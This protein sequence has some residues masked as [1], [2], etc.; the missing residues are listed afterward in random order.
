MKPLEVLSWSLR[1]VI[2]AS[3]GKEIIGADFSAIEA[4]VLAWLAGQDDVLAVLADP[5][6]DLYVEDAR[7]I[8]SDSRQLGKVCRLALGYSMGPIKFRDTAKTYGIDLAL[9]EARRITLLWRKNNAHIVS[10]WEDLERACLDAVFAPRTLRSVGPFLKVAATPE[11]LLIRLPSG[12]AIRYWRPS[13]RKVTKTIQTV[14]EEGE[15][16][17][18][19]RESTVLRF[20]TAG[21]DGSGMAPEETYG[22][23]LVENVTQAVARDLLGYAVL[24]LDPSY[25]VVVHVHDSIASEVPCGTGSVEEFCKIM[26]TS[27][28]WAPGL[29]LAAEG[30]RATRFKG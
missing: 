6:R 7:A 18:M 21:M 27:P 15:I 22:G 2:A 5:K 28:A 17:E 13:V 29:P 1:S 20:Y 3:P 23:K 4:R 24:Q 25:P 26:A 11:C 8:N 10:L 30:Y 12:R 9:K 16:V 14:D 19:E